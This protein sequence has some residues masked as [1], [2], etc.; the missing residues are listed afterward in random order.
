MFKISNII[1]LAV[2]LTFFIG[3][4]SEDLCDNIICLNEGICES[5]DCDCPLGYEGTTCET[6]SR[7]KFLGSYLYDSGTCNN[8]PM[9]FEILADSAN[10]TGILILSLDSFGEYFETPFNL[11][12]E[13]S[14]A[15]SCGNLTTVFLGNTLTLTGFG[16][17]D[18][19]IKQ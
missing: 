8:Y 18:I 4:D 9:N 5:G 7:A 2:A 14:Y 19:F 6:E 12:S 17:D 1:L 16:C 13:N 15:T 10:V 11:V 3:C